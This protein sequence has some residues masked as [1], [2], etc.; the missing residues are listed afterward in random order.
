MKPVKLLV[1]YSESGIGFRTSNIGGIFIDI[2]NLPLADVECVPIPVYVNF[3]SVRARH[4]IF[5][6]RS[7]ATG[8]GICEFFITTVCF[9]N[10]IAT[11]RIIKTYSLHQIRICAKYNLKFLPIG[12]PIT[13][14]VHRRSVCIEILH[15]IRKTVAVT[16]VLQGFC[17]Y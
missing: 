15:T 12:K 6:G 16:I 11:V 2:A 14:S 13:I 7:S 4:E 9:Y 10:H 5:P 1:S 8:F 3:T 17:L